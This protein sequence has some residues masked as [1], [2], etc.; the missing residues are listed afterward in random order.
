MST[1]AEATE[2]TFDADVAK[3][4]IPVL[5]AFCAGWSGRCQSLRTW[6]ETVAVELDGVVKMVAVDV[7]ASGGLGLRYRVVNVPTLV[8][9]RNGVETLRVETVLSLEALRSTILP[10]LDVDYLNANS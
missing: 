3:V 10:H 8:L 4:D 7:D 5:V 6:L 9:F 2:K 1:V